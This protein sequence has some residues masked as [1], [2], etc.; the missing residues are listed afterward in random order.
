M[1]LIASYVW[2]FWLIWLVVIILIYEQSQLP[3][4][5]EEKTPC[6]IL[7][8]PD[9]KYVVSTVQRPDEWSIVF[10]KEHRWYIETTFCV[11]ANEFDSL[12]QA[13]RFRQKYIDQDPRQFIPIT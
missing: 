1:D 5:V 12:E 9:W 13:K 4:T 6:Y 2:V 3:K 8:R 10:L 11:F 7:L